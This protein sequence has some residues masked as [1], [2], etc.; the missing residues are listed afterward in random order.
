MTGVRAIDTREACPTFTLAVAEIEP[1]IAVMESVPTPFAV[2]NP[3]PLTE[4]TEFAEEAQTTVAVKTC[5]VP[6]LYVPVAVSCW[7]EPFAKETLAG[8]TDN[9]FKTA[10]VTVSVTEPVIVPE[11]AV[12]IAVPGDTPVPSPTLLTLA[13]EAADELQVTVVVRF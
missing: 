11:V 10:A 1:E 8:V 3:V 6:S 13:T 7:P 2:T 5:V 4:A 12:M 9:E